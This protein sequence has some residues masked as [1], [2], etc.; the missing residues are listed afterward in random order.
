V[1]KQEACRVITETGIVPAIRVSS[2][3]DAAF[4]AEAIARAGIPIVEITMTVPGA[5]EV[6]ALLTRNNPKLLV[7]AGTV[8]TLDVARECADAGASFL[9]APGFD[10]EI[11]E[12]ASKQDL[13]SLPGALTP[14]EVVHAWRAGADI[15]KVF[16]C[17]PVG[18]SNY[19]KS[20]K[21]SLKQIPL[22]AAGGVNQKTAIDFI[23]A[24]AAA[25]GV[26]AE[27]IPT[28]AI[29]QRSTDRIR[30]LARRFLGYVKDARERLR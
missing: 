14:T 5:V 4:A 23:L 6:I 9:T 22:M 19:I 8:L 7:G 1:R 21:K 2:A 24:G 18:G 13:A 10:P 11:V 3:E 25:I 29:L 12:F 17:A 20:L 30:E 16:P 27:L 28:D 15:V 26:G